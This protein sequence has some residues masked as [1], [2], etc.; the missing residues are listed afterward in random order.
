[1]ITLA[2]V[3]GAAQRL[4]GRI[5]RTPTLSSRTLSELT[6]GTVHLK[7]EL[8]QRT[9]AFKVRGALNKVDSLTQEERARGV[10]SISAGNHA[11]AIAYACAQSEVDCLVLMWKSASPLKVDATREYGATVD[12]DSA[13]PDEAYDRLPLIM[14]ETGRVLV[15]PFDDPIVMAGQ[16][17]VG[18]EI[19]DQVSDVDSVIVATSGGGLISGVATAVKGRH[20]DAR[21][22]AVQAAASPS[23][24]EAKKAGGSVRFAQSPSIADA[25]TA[26]Y[27]GKG[28]FE[29]CERLVDDVVLLSE[30]EIAEGMRFLYGRAKLACEAAAAT[31]V[32]ALLASKLDIRDRPA[33]AVVSGGNIAPDAAA[34]ILA[35][36][37]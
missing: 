9:G 7:A 14:E 12:L 21:V 18:L 17:T 24:I 33:V 16:G 13:N 23:L 3:E 32:A 10:I 2:D 25:L 6:G 4:H 5:H 28:C 19:C 22:I 36:Q 34:R 26:P 1:M 27:F 37:P 11:Q 29:V 31:P 30:D 8:F 15:H 35:G 20:P